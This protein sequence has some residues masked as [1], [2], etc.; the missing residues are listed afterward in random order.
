MNSKMSFFNK[1]LYLSDMKRY[2]WIGAL[3][4]LLIFMG[5]VIP[6]Y[7]SPYQ[8]YGSSS[9][10]YWGGSAF[11]F[12]SIFSIGAGVILMSFLNSNGSVSMMHS[13]PIERKCIFSTKIIS[14]LT[15]LMIPVFIASIALLGLSLDIVYNNIH[16][17]E[18]AKWLY[19]LFCYTIFFLSFTMLVGMMT[20]NSVG[21]IVF[22]IGFIFLPL[23]LAELME[24][25][26]RNEL[27]G[28]SQM[29]L[30]RFLEW[31][32][33]GVSDTLTKKYW[34][35]Y[36]VLSVLFTGG[37]YMLYRKRKSESHGEVI[38][39]KGLKPVFV[40]IVAIMA[41]GIGYMYTQ[42]VFNVQNLFTMLP[43]GIIG[44]ATAHMISKKTLDFKGSIKP[45][46]VYLIAAICFIGAIHFDITGYEKRVPD[47]DKI[48]NVSVDLGSSYND[49][50][51]PHNVI[52]SS[53]EGIKAISDLHS[54]LTETESDV[55]N[56]HIRITY[57][58]K[59]G[60]T[61]CREYYINLYEHEEDLKPLFETEE[62]LKE[63]FE[64]LKPLQEHEITYIDVVDKMHDKTYFFDDKDFEKLLT[65]IKKDMLSYSYENIV[66]T[67]SP[68]MEIHLSYEYYSYKEDS[69]E[70]N[71]L[72]FRV[73]DD[74]VN[75]LNTL[76]EIG[77]YEEIDTE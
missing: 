19:G 9:F 56:S 47:V 54:A 12:S 61:L 31:F 70:Y 15:L 30:Y 39:F 3:Y 8:T 24:E 60:S 52:F 50:K 43:L 45:A 26:L 6:L 1:A 51:I 48:E 2:W 29:D 22:T 40:A 17:I 32:Y 37:A 23:F 13:L 33:L 5:C 41:S 49:Y 73:Y 53:K 46:I 76:K 42:G 4:T 64:I 27:H 38:A 72:T 35:V 16:A 14:A 71:Q 36:P 34:Y 57:K 74:C 75:T 28:F 69:T 18:V 67:S 65:A 11:V 44:T 20:G 58:L 66:T 55:K 63:N 77:F 7:E 10:T 59:N 25:L 68:L 62:F 21:N